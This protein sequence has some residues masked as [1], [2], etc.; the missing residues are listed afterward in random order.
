[1]PQCVSQAEFLCLAFRERYKSLLTKA[2]TNAPEHGGTLDFLRLLSR[3]ER[4]CAR[5]GII[6]SPRHWRAWTRGDCKLWRKRANFFLL[7]TPACSQRA[8][9]D[10]GR[11]SM[12]DFQDWRYTTVVSF[13]L[14]CVFHT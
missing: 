9:L 10:A 6:I 14:S 4:N 3:E 1:M 12:T 8:V 7:P 5:A 13:H 2:H 11:K